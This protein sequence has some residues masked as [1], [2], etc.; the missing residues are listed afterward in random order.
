MATY[1]VIS[2]CGHF[3]L[4]V[5]HL[6][7]CC[8][9]WVCGRFVSFRLFYVSLWQVCIYLDIFCHFA[10]VLHTLLT[11]VLCV[12][13]HAFCIMFCV[14]LPTIPSQLPADS[15]GWPIGMVSQNW[16][17]VPPLT[18]PLAQSLILFYFNKVWLLIAASTWNCQ[19]DTYNIFYCS[20]VE[21][22]L[23]VIL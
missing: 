9:A 21:L 7:C 23:S 5:L 2:L 16:W 20:F 10:V 14:I 1:V 11:D 15:G 3:F 6:F 8:L 13:L 18:I 19:I 12:V 17:P 4:V 22:L